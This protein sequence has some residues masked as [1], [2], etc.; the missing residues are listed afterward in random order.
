MP[1]IPL[2]VGL[3]LA[4]CQGALAQN[5]PPASPNAPLRLTLA[6]AMERARTNSPQILSANIA[7]LIARE[8]TVQAKAALLP[9][10]KR[11]NQYIYTQ[12][13]GT[14]TG[15]FVSNDGVHVYNNRARRARRYVR[16]AQARRLPQ[17]PWRPKPWPRPKR[18]SPRAA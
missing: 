11:F 2:I 6:D 12:P 17:E 7:A 10:V 13:N 4:L 1:H 9:T 14:L 16:S 5:P 3:G 18:K 15:M 8:D